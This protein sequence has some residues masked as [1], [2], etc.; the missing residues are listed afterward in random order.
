MKKLGILVTSLVLGLSSV[1]LATPAGYGTATRDHRGPAIAPIVRDHRP[2]LAQPAR[3]ST[4]ASNAKLTRGRALIDVSTKKTFTKLQLT[5]TGPMFVDRIAV[6][7]VNGRTRVIE[8]D[9]RLVGRT[10]LAIDLPGL[11]G[12]SRVID[13]LV[14]YGRGNARAVLTVKAL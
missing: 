11:A 12:R 8:V 14:I 13:K 1:A 7:F 9:K 4:L 3:W 5:S 2:P 10:A 6:T